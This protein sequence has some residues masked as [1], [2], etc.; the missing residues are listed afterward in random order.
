MEEKHDCKKRGLYYYVCP[1]LC[2]KR[3]LERVRGAIVI[4]AFA[5]SL[6]H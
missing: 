1:Y 3:L 2:K 6:H 5:T 4:V